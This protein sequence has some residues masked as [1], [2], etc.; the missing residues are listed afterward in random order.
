MSIISQ[1]NDIEDIVAFLISR[2][3]ET[4]HQRDRMEAPVL[5]DIIA[6]EFKAELDKIRRL[7]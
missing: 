4:W 6:Y 5:M 1:A 3:E 7:I 2:C